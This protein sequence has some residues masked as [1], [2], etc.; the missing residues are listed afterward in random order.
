MHLETDSGFWM[1]EGRVLVTR[2][3]GGLASC[4]GASFQQMGGG[5]LCISGADGRGVAQDSMVLY[6]AEARE[7]LRLTLPKGLPPRYGYASCSVGPEAVAVHGGFCSGCAEDAHSLFVLSFLTQAARI[8][9]RRVRLNNVLP[10]PR[11]NH[12]C[13]MLDPVL[14]LL[15]GGRDR[16]SR[17]LADVYVV[18]TRNGRGERLRAPLPAAL[19]GHTLTRAG[20][21][22][23]LFGGM[24]N[25]R[26]DCV[27]GS[28]YVFDKERRTFA[29]VSAEGPALAR[30]TTLSFA[31]SL[32]VLNGV[33][34]DGTL[35]S[36]LHAY[37]IRANTWSSA[38]LLLDGR[39]YGRA[40][41]A[42]GLVD[43]DV[44]VYGG[45]D[46]GQACAEDLLV[47]ELPPLAALHA[48]AASPAL[49]AEHG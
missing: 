25:G 42:C 4:V 24:V 47:I 33:A 45:R 49:P 5:L 27:S 14:L 30:H 1:P 31:G 10:S 40:A 2:L 9:V 12:A 18:N 39:P 15:A 46:A 21:A 23:Y 19:E 48:S 32:L 11:F 16:F 28:L 44:L 36:R 8:D 20:D 26:E 7:L 37:D 17:A 35:N 13:A 6:A 3:A 43:G 41:C 34:G 38:E 29:L 22:V